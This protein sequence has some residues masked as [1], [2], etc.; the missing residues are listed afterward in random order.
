MWFDARDK[1]DEIAGQL[2]ATSAVTAHPV[3]QMSQRPRANKSTLSVAEVA[4]V[5]APSN[6]E[7]APPLGPTGWAKVPWTPHAAFP[8]PGDPWLGLGVSCLWPTGET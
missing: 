1:L 6:S 8:R 2:P 3:T 7:T 4:N 5:A